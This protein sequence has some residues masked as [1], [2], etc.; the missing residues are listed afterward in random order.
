MALTR[1]KKAEILADLQGIVKKNASLVFVSFNK[2]PVSLATELRRK[3][4]EKSIGYRVAKKTLITKAFEGD[5]FQ[6]EIP[7]LP[8]E[9][10]LAYGAD[11]I[12]P[13]REVYGFQKDHKENISILG[14]VF[15]GKFLDQTAMMNIAMIPPIEVLYG[16]L[17]GLLA[18]PY[19]KLVVALDQ[20]A[21][22][23]APSA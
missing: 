12:A 4:R 14:G 11:M 19:R 7:P 3:L 9:V 20:I 22:K 1:E 5:A 16:Q 6:G 8:G 10:A 23:Q 2:L 13:A 21:K 18:S 17:V 15:E